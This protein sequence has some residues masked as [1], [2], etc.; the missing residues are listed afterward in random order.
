MEEI[1]GFDPKDVEENKVLAAISYLGI[2]V[3]VP[4]LMKK[5]SRFVKEHSR[6]GLALFIAEVILWLVEMIFAW[7]PVLGTIVLILAWI[8]W[9]IIIIVSII[10]LIYAIQGKFWKIP[11]V[12]DWA[13]N[14]KI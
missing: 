10:G 9:V 14:L 11:I 4:L 1:T 7:I 12:Y 2:L 6:Q 3:L 13:Q 5:D 8:A